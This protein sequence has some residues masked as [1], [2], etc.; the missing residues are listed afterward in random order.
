[1]GRKHIWILPYSGKE[2]Y[3]HAEASDVS[4]YKQWKDVYPDG[5]SATVES[6]SM[7]A[8]GEIQV[9]SSFITAQLGD[10]VTLENS[11]WRMEIWSYLTGG[12]AYLRAKIYRYRD[13]VETL[14]FT[15]SDSASVG[16]AYSKIV[17]VYQAIETFE[18]LPTDRL[19]VKIFANITV[20]GVGKKI[21]IAYDHSTRNSLV[22]DPSIVGTSTITE[23]VVYSS[24]KKT[25]FCSGNSRWY[26]WYNDGTNFGWKTSLDGVSWTAFTVYGAG[27]S[28][29]IDLWYDEPNNKICLVR[30]T[31]AAGQN[32]YRQGTANS[33]GSITWDSDEVV[34]H[35]SDI[36]SSIENVVKDSNGYPWISYKDSAQN[37]KVVKATTTSG[38]AWGSPT[39]LWANRATGSE[40]IKIVPLTLG[41]MLAISSAN[42]KVF[43]SRLFDGSSWVAAVN[44]ST[45]TPYSF[46]YFDAVADGDNAHLVFVDSSGSYNVIYVKYNYGSG[47]GSQETVEASTYY[48]YHPSVT[49]KSEDKVRV[50]YLKSATTIKYRDRDTG[51]W[52]TAVTISSTEASMTCL[53]SSYKAFSSK[54][55]VIWEGG[56]TSPYS[57]KFEGY[58]IAIPVVAPKIVGDGLTWVV[59]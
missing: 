30:V 39:T 10:N 34:F 53:S 45:S 7:G 47:W 1:M 12:T 44:A 18:L 42:G 9:G 26:A 14:L 43:Q 23:A 57:V 52:Q 19:I 32:Y 37:E 11:N 3:L 24:Q 33:D 27:S 21:Y 48:Y 15:T 17:W 50:F 51:A 56:A 5:A 2:S 38:S 41:K 59:A 49:L 25:F 22:V 4:G 16:T 58:T 40:R 46:E 54:F 6:A 28:A 8:T 35:A 55:S 36:V 13:A 29:F 31:G 20:K